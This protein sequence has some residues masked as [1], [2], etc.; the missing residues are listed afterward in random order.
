MALWQRS[1]LQVDSS[2]YQVSS[3]KKLRRSLRGKLGR[4]A[5]VNVRLEVVGKPWRC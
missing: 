3:L 5:C 1:V 4:L 2:L